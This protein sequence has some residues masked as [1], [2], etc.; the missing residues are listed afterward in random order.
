MEVNAQFVFVVWLLVAFIPFDMLLSCV[1][2]SVLVRASIFHL[3]ALIHL[4]S[5]LC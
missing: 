1:C 2:V 5:T 4:F 3:Y